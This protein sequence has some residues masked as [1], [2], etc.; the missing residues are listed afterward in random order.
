MGQYFIV[1]TGAL[2]AWVC[3]MTWRGGLGVAWVALCLTGSGCA[4]VRQAREAQDSRRIPAGERTVTAAELGL[5]AETVLTLER[6][7]QVALTYHPAMVQA[8]QTVVAASNG[9]VQAQAARAPSVGASA[10]Y[11]R[12]TS[13]TAAKSGRNTSADS[14]SAGVSAD[15]LLYDFGRTAASIRQA[16]A[17]LQSAVE[18]LR[19]ARNDV[20]YGTRVAFYELSRAQEFL[21]VAEET[22]RQYVKRLGQV[23]ALAEVGRRIKY[24]ITKAEVDLGNA[25][26]DLINARNA[27]ADARAALMRSLG[28]AEDP[29]CRIAGCPPVEVAWTLEDRLEVARRVQPG[30][31][32]VQAQVRAASAAVD[33]AVADLYPSLSLSG[34]YLWNGSALPLFWNW[35]G[36]A[37]AGWNLFDGGRKAA[38]VNAAVANLRAARAQAADR[39]QQIYLDL[40]TAFTQLAGARE[41]EGL[42]GL[43]VKQAG[44][45]LNLVSERYRIGQA[46]SVELTDA[47]V[48]LSQA[49]A[50][51]VKARFDYQSAMA[52]IMRTTGEDEQ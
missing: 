27:V 22:E 8:R 44:E 2:M 21:G 46:S 45:N 29:Q 9:L 4:T 12:G 49:R 35:A 52:A 38:A 25:R 33:G 23:Q 28:L 32:A 3:R 34:E 42:T 5:K 11:R 41:R 40:R 30:L 37:R 48:S 16:E 26:L 43:I 15:Q 50:N 36:A 39:E 24:D 7:A 20:V 10:G 17:S 51:Q 31:K 18:G 47:Q 14:Y 13:N 6:A 1:G 19:G